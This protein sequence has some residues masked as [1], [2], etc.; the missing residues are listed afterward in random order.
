VPTPYG[1]YHKEVCDEKVDHGTFCSFCQSETNQY[2]YC[3][4]FKKIE[5]PRK[6]PREW[7]EA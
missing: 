2:I 7:D 4:A 1:C 5:K 3:E 6:Y